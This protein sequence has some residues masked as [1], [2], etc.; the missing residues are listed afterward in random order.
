[1]VGAGFDDASFTSYKTVYIPGVFVSTG[2][3]VI[4]LAVISPSSL[5]VA[6]AHEST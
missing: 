5:S 3:V 6:V 4:I 1:M 2:F